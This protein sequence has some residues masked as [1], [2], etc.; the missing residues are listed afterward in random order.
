MKYKNYNNSIEMVE[1][2]VINMIISISIYIYIYANCI[3]IY[4]LV[5]PQGIGKWLTDID[6]NFF[7]ILICD[8]LCIIKIWKSKFL[9][10]LVKYLRFFNV[11]LVD[12]INILH[13]C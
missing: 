8:F 3:Y 6:C 7:Q 13:I 2:C 1:L 11:V 10:K 4:I 9:F 5:I 12:H